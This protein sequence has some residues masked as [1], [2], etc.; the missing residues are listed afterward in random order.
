MTEPNDLTLCR[1]GELMRRG[2]LSA[3]ALVDA[4]L[5]RIAEREPTVRAW[6]RLYGEE[7]RETARRR[8]REA[9]RHQWQGPL[10]GLP[11]GIKD[12]YDVQ[13]MT[14]EAGTAAYP[15]RIAD[16]DAESVARLR[17]A[18]AIVLGKTVTTA[19]AMGDAG[20]TRNPWHPDHTPG[21]SSSGSGAGVA[22][23]M[24]LGALGTQ[25]NGSV[26]RPASFNGIVGFKPGYGE[27]SAEG[28]LPLSWQLDHVGCL[29]RS[30]EDAHLL[31][32]LMRDPRSL[33]W[34]ATRDKMGPPLLPRAP[35]R[36]WRVR[37]YFEEEAHPEMLAALEACC[38]VLSERGVEVVERPLPPPCEGMHA[39]HHTIMSCEAATFHKPAFTSDPGPFPPKISG[40]I[41]EGLACSA[42]DYLAALRQRER[43]IVHL[44]ATLADVDAA[45]LPAA[46][47]PA[48][49]GLESTGS[50]A[51][52]TLA[53]LCGLPAI[54]LPAGLSS[55]GLP[56]GVQLVGG[57]GRDHELLAVAAWYE[58][59][60][61][62]DAA[63]GGA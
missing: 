47:G 26:L 5:A 50:P 43:L 48:P 44:G 52:N 22:D 23:R 28:V 1:A 25:T 15:S 32:H 6:A 17:D 33:D 29:T 13:G 12:I 38:G 9:A 24:C 45:I 51:F 59:V 37:G 27:I 10:H 39:L 11:L 41:S 62:F 16:K 54:S 55:T 58:S 63:P 42:T 14:T 53:S 20:P 3:E 18:G 56:L 40:L 21:G 31:W 7:A 30:V 36:V 2:R 60:L 49:A 4:C 8:D 46:Q 57:A 19:F 61:A 35:E 34:Q